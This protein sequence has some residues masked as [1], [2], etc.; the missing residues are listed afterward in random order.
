MPKN[1]L[2]ARVSGPWVGLLTLVLV[3]AVLSLAK[4]V[5]LPLALGIV[6]AFTLSPLVRLFDRW[7][8]PRV[9]GVALT[10]ILALGTVGGIGYVVFNQFSDLSAQVTKYT[11]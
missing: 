6:L 9:L 11:S 3:V 4:A 10:M 7:R 1:Q 5:L 2:F 8:F